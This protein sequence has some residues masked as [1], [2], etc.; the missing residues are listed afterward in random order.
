MQLRTI[1]YH[2][3]KLFFG[4]K[5]NIWSK[6][7]YFFKIKTLKIYIK[8]HCLQTAPPTGGAVDGAMII[9]SITLIFCLNSQLDIFFFYIKFPLKHL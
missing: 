3:P 8:H 6:I 2:N 9:F 7:V 5:S 4:E 1:K